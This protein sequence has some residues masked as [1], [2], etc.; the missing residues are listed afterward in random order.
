VARDYHIDG[1]RLDAVHALED[2]R[3]CTSGAARGRM[4]ALP[5]SWTGLLLIAESDGNDPGW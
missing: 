1:L 4:Q 2:H 3:A 5:R